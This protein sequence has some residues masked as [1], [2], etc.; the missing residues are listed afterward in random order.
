MAAVNTLLSQAVVDPGNAWLK[1]ARAN[2]DRHRA[3]AETHDTTART[4]EALT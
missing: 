2:A 4:A 3:I 1:G